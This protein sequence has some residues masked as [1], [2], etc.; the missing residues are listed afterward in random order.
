MIPVFKP[1][2]GEEEKGAARSVLDEGWLGM[3][4]NVGEFEKNVNEFL[5]LENRQCVAV[6]TGPAALHLGLL[7]MGV[8]PGDEVITP[9]FNNVL[10]KFA[11]RARNIS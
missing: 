9:S 4:K 2:V 5:K 1:L 10:P 6:S 3:G 8:G 7:A 11:K